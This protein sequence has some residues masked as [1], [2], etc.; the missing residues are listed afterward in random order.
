MET[1]L[2]LKQQL[3]R[4]YTRF[5]AFIVPILK[6]FAMLFAMIF[7]N[8]QFFFYMTLQKQYLL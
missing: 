8:Q 5:E 4:L 2:V 1:L 3:M 7:I 6:F